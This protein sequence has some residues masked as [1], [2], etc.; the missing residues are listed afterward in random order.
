MKVKTE[1]KYLVLSKNTL[2]REDINFSNHLT[3]LKKALTRDLTTFS[4]FTLPKT[5]GISKV[6]YPCH[7]RSSN[8]V[9]KKK[10]KLTYFSI[11]L[12]K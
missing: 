10:K 1:V 11:H 2:R 3:D 12:E 6:I 9:K 8:N 5:Q 7:S 4:R